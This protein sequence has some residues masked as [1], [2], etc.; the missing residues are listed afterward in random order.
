MQANNVEH[1]WLATSVYV[2]LDLGCLLNCYSFR[3][4]PLRRE[5]ASQ[6][7]IISQIIG[8]RSI[9]S[10]WFSRTWIVQEAASNPETT[11]WT[12]P[13]SVPWHRFVLWALKLYTEDERQR[14]HIYSV[15]NIKQ[16]WGLRILNERN[17]GNKTTGVS[18]Y[19]LLRAFRIFDS[20]DPRD[21]VYGALGLAEDATFYPLP[22]Y[23]KDVETVYTEFAR[24]AF[25]NQPSDNCVIL[26]DAGITKQRLKLPSWVPDWSFSSPDVTAKAFAWLRGQRVLP[27][28]TNSV[29]R[30]EEG[31]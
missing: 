4:N 31:V 21:K 11:V 26:T 9:D 1:L 7:E 24:V 23:S 10:P 20:T 5:D 30:E 22:D 6:E 19:D 14:R 18:L 29:S 8:L 13:L 15:S 25:G 16:I 12:G 27:P 17:N 2:W 3:Q 28:R